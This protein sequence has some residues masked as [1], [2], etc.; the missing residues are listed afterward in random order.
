LPARNFTTRRLILVATTPGEFLNVTI[1]LARTFALTLAVSYASASAATFVVKNVD[2]AGAGS[3]RS[4]IE[5]A[6]A[7]PGLDV[8]EFNIPGPRPFTIKPLSPL[9]P[10]VSPIVIDGTFA[11][12]PGVELTG[13]SAVGEL[14]KAL[15]LV[16]GS[17]GST[18]R[19]LVINDFSGGGILIFNSDDHVIAGNWI[20]LDDNGITRFAN[21]S[22][23]V[24]V[25]ASSHTIIGGSTPRDRNVI[26]ANYVAEIRSDHAT[27]LVIEGNYINTDVSGFEY[28]YANDTGFYTGIN[29][30]DTKDSRV[31][32]DSEAQRN[33]VGGLTS[34]GGTSTGNVIRGNNL[35]IAV[36]GVTMLNRGVA[37]G[38]SASSNSIVE[39]RIG[40][41]GG[42][43]V[44]VYSP[45]NGVLISH[46]SIRA[47][48]ESSLAINLDPAVG[49]RTLNDSLDTDTGANLL[50][51]YPMLVSASNIAGEIAIRGVMDSTPATNLTLEFFWSAQCTPL[52]VGHGDFLGSKVVTT[53]AG[54]HAEFEVRFA[55]ASSGIVSATARDPQNNTSEFSACKAI[56]GSVPEGTLFHFERSAVAV[57]EN[58]GVAALL[59]LRDGPQSTVTVHYRTETD[60]TSDPGFSSV[61]GD[62]SFSVESS[63]VIFVPLVNDD[64]A[65]GPRTFRVVITGL[66]GAGAIGQPSVVTVTI[67]DDETEPPPTD[68]SRRRPVKRSR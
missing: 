16:K 42:D 21:R 26:A 19:G 7:T 66:N 62:S 17:D 50:Q 15:E 45:A 60:R 58:E 36:D 54:G 2:D 46:N 41:E 43:A 30:F 33:I 28:Q 37:C 20:G 32:G 67:H 23:G 52:G 65:N 48:Y 3:L 1:A 14:V 4:A 9:P 68:P 53:D 63:H 64:V 5:S 10:V 31:G 57:R 44:R 11:D 51:N 55:G 22:V 47:G 49:Q 12:R 61:D 27:G 24:N 29:L 13:T 40:T 25:L 34:I 38:V 56:D 18:I 6:N 39:N 35:G 8:V 59:L